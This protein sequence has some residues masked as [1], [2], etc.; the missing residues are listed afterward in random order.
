MSKIVSFILPFDEPLDRYIKQK[1]PKCDSFRVVSQSLDARKANKGKKPKYQYQVELVSSDETFHRY[2]ETFKP[3]DLKSRPIIIGAG[4]AGLFCALRFAE[5]GVPTTIIERGSEAHRRMI[6]ISKYWRSGTL[7]QEDNVCYGEGGAGLFSDGKLITRIKSP[8]I[9]Y[10]MNKLV[11]FGAPEEIAYMS[12]PHLG[13]NKIRKIISVISQSLINDGHEFI[14]NNKVNEIIFNDQKVSGVK[15]NDGT[16][17]VSDHIVL[18]TGHSAHGIY[19]HLAK[20]QVAMKKKDFSVGVR[21]EHKRERIDKIQH[22]DWFDHSLLG[23]ARY[24]LSHHNKETQRGT[25][26]FCMCP[27]GY[28]LSSGTDGDGIVANG[29]SNYA[30][31]SHWSNAALVVTVKADEDLDPNDILSGIDFQRDIEKKAFQLSQKYASGKELPAMTIGDFLK[32]KLSD[33]DLPYSSCPSKLIKVNLWDVF[34]NFICEHLVTALS[35]FEHKME[36][37]SKDAL[38]IAPET[39]TSSPVTISRD[40]ETLESLSHE[41]LYPCGEGAGYAGG[42]TSAA[43]DGVR[44]AESILK[45]D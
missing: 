43:V 7:N 39:R 24:R 2:Q 28:V 35:S 13:S 40:K 22:G 26:S 20:N 32:R 29:M 42:I 1:Y 45:R 31:N 3:K 27:G 6:S 17:L 12:N 34:P 16:E 18:A 14:Y 44:V 38:L 11:E 4:P 37:F 15:L 25:Y 36:G 10:V 23:A 21:I 30:R 5:Y 9:Q 19:R 33:D 41:S 8:H